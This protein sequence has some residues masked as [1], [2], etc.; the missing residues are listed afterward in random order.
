M[1]QTTDTPE[2]PVLEATGGLVVGLW[3]CSWP[4]ASVALYSDRVEFKT[5]TRV[6]YTL[7]KSDIVSFTSMGWLPTPITRGVRFLHRRSDYAEKFEFWTSSRDEFLAALQAHNFG[8][9]RTDGPEQAT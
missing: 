9:Y 8:Q 6:R 5:V 4:F 3:S 7:T 1:E 2:S